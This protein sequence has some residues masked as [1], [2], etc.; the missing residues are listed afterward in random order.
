M[1]LTKTFVFTALAAGSMIA[2]GSAFAQDATNAPAPAPEISTNYPPARPHPMY[3]GASIERL[4]QML[5]LTDDQKAQVEPILTAE[6]QKMRDLRN[7]T[8]LTTDEKRSK[9]K[10]IRDDTTAQL[11]PILTPDQFAKWQSMTHPPRRPMSHPMIPASTN[12]PAGS[13]Q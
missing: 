3:R 11:Q 1:K 10:E 4:A 5:N 13:A 6:R 8:S 12:T 7:D 9:M 2:C